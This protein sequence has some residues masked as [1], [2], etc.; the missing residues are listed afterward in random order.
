MLCQPGVG[1]QV[2]QPATCTPLAGNQQPKSRYNCG[3]NPLEVKSTQRGDGNLGLQ[4]IH[5]YPVNHPGHMYRQYTNL[6][7]TCFMKSV[8][9]N[10][11][12]WMYALLTPLQ[13]VK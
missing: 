12:V 13:L 9:E 4:L 11:D 8:A 2:R 6:Q 5:N 1:P 3:Y 10:L 7:K